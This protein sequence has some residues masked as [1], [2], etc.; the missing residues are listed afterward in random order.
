M[1]AAATDDDQAMWKGSKAVHF[2][3][4]VDGHVYTV[5]ASNKDVIRAMRQEATHLGQGREDE[6]AQALLAQAR[7]VHCFQVCT[8]VLL[9][10]GSIASGMTLQ[11][12]LP[13]LS[14]KVTSVQRRC[15]H[16]VVKVT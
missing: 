4:L 14:T 5:D 12:R 7:R 16:T 10:L 9:H 13:L 15:G 3:D 1:L 2:D 8:P 11:S 6:F